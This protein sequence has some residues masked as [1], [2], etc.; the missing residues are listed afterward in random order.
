MLLF[1]AQ[2]AIF[3]PVLIASCPR[4]S[5]GSTCEC[6][7][8]FWLD[9]RGIYCSVCPHTTSCAGGS[10]LPIARPGYYVISTGPFSVAE[11][12]GK[13]SKCLGGNLCVDG[14][15]GSLCNEC[16]SGYKPY[17]SPTVYGEIQ[18]EKCMS[19]LGCWRGLPVWSVALICTF[20]SLLEIYLISRSLRK[21]RFLCFRDRHEEIRIVDDNDSLY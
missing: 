14:Y 8:G 3:L 15:T 10:S 6:D 7:P 19:G 16:A 9:P 11:C 21:H 2:A 17:G 20:V 18:C 5:S 12:P 13:T 4:F 1:L